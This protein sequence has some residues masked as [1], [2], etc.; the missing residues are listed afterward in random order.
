MGSTAT[1]YNMFVIIQDKD[2]PTSLY[3]DEIEVTTFTTPQEAFD[4][5]AEHEPG[6]PVICCITPHGNP[7]L[8]HVLRYTEPPGWPAQDFMEQ[9]EDQRAE[10]REHQ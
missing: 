8:V 4:F 2:G 6:T 9:A 1:K 7:Q 10:D 3:D 5:M